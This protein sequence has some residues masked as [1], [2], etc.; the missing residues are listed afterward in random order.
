[1]KLGY[2]MPTMLNTSTAEELH[3][4]SNEIEYGTTTIKYKL[5][6]LK[7]FPIKLFTNTA[8]EAVNGDYFIINFRHRACVPGDDVVGLPLNAGVYMDVLKRSKNNSIELIADKSKL[9]GVKKYETIRLLNF[10]EFNEIYGTAPETFSGLVTDS[11]LKDIDNNVS[12]SLIK[13]YN[14]YVENPNIY[15]LTKDYVSIFISE[16][17][18]S[19]K[20]RLDDEVE[21]DLVKQ[22]VNIYFELTKDY[23]DV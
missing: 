22:V 1:M 9:D 15:M 5:S 19:D 16:L 4:N 11:M 21:V 2:Y 17:V 23:A 7:K 14:Y 6:K 3:E 13:A 10:Y 18:G 20:L 12:F 8:N